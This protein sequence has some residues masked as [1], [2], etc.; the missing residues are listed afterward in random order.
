M[1]SF[2]KKKCGFFV[3]EGF[4]IH[5]FYLYKKKTKIRNQYNQVPHETQHTMW[6]SDK[7]IRKH[8]TQDVSHFP[9]ANHKALGNRQDI[10]IKQT[11]NIDNKNYPQKR[12]RSGMVSKKHCSLTCLTVPTSPLI[13][14]QIKS[15]RRLV[16]MKDPII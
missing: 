11:F 5:I 7:N 14:M 12:H 10:I 16:R 8:H 4:S 9:A 1:A 15:H 3:K 13:L 6:E 2:I